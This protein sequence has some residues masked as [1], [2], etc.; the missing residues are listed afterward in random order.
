L[1]ISFSSIVDFHLSNFRFEDLAEHP[2][3]GSSISE[4]ELYA[5]SLR[6]DYS[7]TCPNKLLKVSEL[8]LAPFAREAGKEPRTHF[9]EYRLSLEVKHFPR[10]Q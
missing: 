8:L 7:S 10:S 6:L 4:P 5:N 9:A 2:V 1:D 3:E